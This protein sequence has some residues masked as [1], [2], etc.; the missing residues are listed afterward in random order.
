MQRIAASFF[1]LLLVAVPGCEKGPVT[2]QAGGTVKYRDGAPLAGGQVKF[3][4]DG[5]PLARTATGFIGP[6]GQFELRTFE[7]GDGAL[8]GRHRVM[9]ISPAA[10]LDE[11]WEKNLLEGG[12]RPKPPSG[13]QLHPRYRS[14]DNSGLSFTVTSNEQENQFDIVVELK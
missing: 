12:A 13:P 5:G 1:L 8:P 11:D 3:Q 14:F 7:D 10:P 4:V 6:D 2:Y 9:I